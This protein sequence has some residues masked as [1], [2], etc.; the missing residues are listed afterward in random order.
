MATN[1]GEVWWKLTDTQ[2][3]IVYLGSPY[4]WSVMASH[5][6]GESEVRVQVGPSTDYVFSMSEARCV[7]D[8]FD[9]G[10]RRERQ[11]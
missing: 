4:V 6:T 5:Y 7:L 9:K 11:R 10:E 1:D 2:G 8:H 3:N